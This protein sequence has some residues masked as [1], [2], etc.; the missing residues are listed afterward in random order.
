M[1][2]Y[3]KLVSMAKLPPKTVERLS[4]YRHVLSKYQNLSEPYIFSHDLANL[5]RLKPVQVRRDMMLL[6][7]SGNYRNGYKVIELL[8][9]IN[10][11]LSIPKST[12]ATIIGMGHLGESLLRHVNSNSICP[13]VI[14]S[15]FE[16]N[17]K[18]INTTIQDVPC[19]DLMRL[20]EI[21]EKERIQIAILALYT[22][23]IQTIIDI[24]IEAG[25]KGFI[26][27]ISGPIH[28]PQHIY[29]KEY[30]IKIS[31]EE[32]SYNIHN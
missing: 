20:S 10:Q 11:T 19:Y 15:T 25:I 4:K 16:T 21:I 6:G 7:T 18:K 32:M 30:D 3:L 8:M 2:P 27:Y 12:S 23:D 31:L 24:L 1:L 14:K 17:P 5:L 29:L 28:V 9:Q 22:D 13:V 26:N